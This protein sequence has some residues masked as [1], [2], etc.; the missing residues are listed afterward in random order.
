MKVELLKVNNTVKVYLYKKRKKS[1]YILN[2]Q[3]V[4]VVN[5]QVKGPAYENNQKLLPTDE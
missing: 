2:T 5:I 4:V 3:N 1:E